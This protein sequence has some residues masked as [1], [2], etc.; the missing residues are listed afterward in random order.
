MV[1][2]K[3]PAD[4]ARSGTSTSK[5]KAKA[6]QASPDPKEDANPPEPPNYVL[7]DLSDDDAPPIH[8]PCPKKESK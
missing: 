1:P 4:P 3:N 5:G 2:K 8:A 7:P 6:H